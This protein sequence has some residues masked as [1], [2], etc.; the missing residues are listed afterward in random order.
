M[1]DDQKKNT[2]EGHVLFFSFFNLFLYMKVITNAGNWTKLIIWI[3]KLM[4][5]SSFAEIS[6]QF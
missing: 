3:K 2:C 5:I 4:L 6:L 1:N